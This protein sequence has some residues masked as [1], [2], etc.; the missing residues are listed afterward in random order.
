MIPFLV[1]L[2]V[3]GKVVYQ[4]VRSATSAAQALEDALTDAGL[5]DTN[6]RSIAVVV[7]KFNPSNTVA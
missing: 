4:E 1:K 2:T 6:P 3:A 5:L 7:R